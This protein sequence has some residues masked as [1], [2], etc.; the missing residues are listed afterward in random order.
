MA[1]KC[2]LGNVKLKKQARHSVCSLHLNSILTLE[3]L[4]DS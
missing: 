2:Y 4:S 1:V 3:M